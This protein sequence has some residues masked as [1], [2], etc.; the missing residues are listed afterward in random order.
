MHQQLELSPKRVSGIH[1]SVERLE[2]THR[3]EKDKSDNE[4]KKPD[5]EGSK[6]IPLS[7]DTRLPDAKTAQVGMV[8]SVTKTESEKQPM[9]ETNKIEAKKKHFSADFTAKK[10]VGITQSA[11][12]TAK[13]PLLVSD[14][15]KSPSCLKN[16]QTSLANSIKKKNPLLLEFEVTDDLELQASDEKLTIPTDQQDIFDQEGYIHVTP[17]SSQ[18]PTSKGPKSPRSPL[19]KTPLHHEE[20]TYAQPIPLSPN[21]YD[22]LMY[23]TDDIELQANKFYGVSIGPK[24]DSTVIANDS[25]MRGDS[26]LEIIYPGSTGSISEKPNGKMH[27]QLELSPKC[28][29]GIHTSVE[30]L[31]P[32]H[33]IEKDKSD[34]EAK[35]PDMEG[36]KT[37]PL[38]HDT[39]LP[40]AKATQVGMVESVTK[41]ESKKQPMKETN[42]IQAMKKH[43]SADFTPKKPAMEGSKT[44]PLSHDTCLLDVKTAQVGM[45]ESVTKTESKKQPMKKTNKIEAKKKHFFADFT[46]KKPVGITQSA[47]DTAKKPLLVSDDLKNP[48]HLKNL[49]T[50]LA[51]RIKKK[52][53]LLLEFEVTDD[54]EL[55]ASDEKLTIPTDQQDIFDQEGYI[56]V[57]PPSSQTP[58]SKGPKSPRSPLT[59]TPLHHEEPTYAQPTPLSPNHYDSLM[60]NTDDIELQANKFYGVSIG[61]K[62]DS[63][64]I[65][66]DSNMRGDSELEIIYPG[67]TGS[68][69]EKPNGKMHQQLELSPKCI[70][71]IHTSVERLEPTHGIEKDKSDNEAKKPDMEGNKTTPL[72]HDTCLPDAKTAQVGMVESVTKT[73]S[74][75]Q[76]MKKTSKIQ[77]TK[78]HLSLDF[79]PKKPDMEGSKTTPLSHDTCLPDAKTTQVGMVES[80]T[81]IESKKQ[82]MKET[83]KIQAMKKHF[84]ADFT[85][86]KPVG[87][88]QSAEDTVKK[89]L[90]VSD[91]LK[92]P[93]RLKNLQTSL[94]N[95]MK[96]TSLH[97][98]E[99]TYA[100]PTPLSPTPYDSVMCNTDDI[101]LQANIVYGVSI[102]PKD[103]STV[104]ANNSNMRGDSELEIIY[105]GSTGSISEKPNRKMHQQLELSPKR[106]SGIHT[107]VERLEPTHRIEKD[108]P[109]SEDKEPNMEGSKTT[110]LSHNTCLPDAKTTQV[111]MV[112]SVTKT[113]SKKQPMKETNKIQAMKKHLSLDFTPKKPAME[114]SK[115][116]PLSHNTCLLD[117]KTA[118]VG[119]VES[120]T[121][122]ESEKQPMKETNKIQAM[123]KHFSAD[124]TPKKPVGITQSAEDTVKKPLLVSDDLKNPSRLKNLQTSLANRIKKKNPLLLEFEVTDD[125]EL[126]ASDEKLT[127]P[128]D[129][130]DIFDQEGYIHVTPPSSQTPTSKGPKSPRSPLT[131]TP[132][133]HEEP[134][135]AQPT[136][137]SPNHYDSLMYNTDDI[138][139]QANIVYGVSIGPKD[140]STVIANDSNMRG[141]SELE[142]IYPGSTGSISEKPNGKMHQQLEL[143][144]KCISGI[145][146]SV[147]RLEPTHRIEKD[148]SDNEAKKPDMEVSKTTPLSHD[149]C[150]PDAKTA[151]V[152]MVESVTKIESK[153]QPMKKTSKIQAMKKHLSLDFTPKKPDMEGSKNTPLSHDTCLPDAKTT[154]VG[155]VESV[156]KIESKKQPMKETNKIQAM[157]KHFSADFT[158]K[159][160]VGITQSAEDTVKKPLLVSDDLKNPSRLKNLQTS[161]AN[162]MKKTSLHHEEP[163]YAQPTPLSP[164]PYD[165]VMCNTD[166][167]ELQ[168]NIVY[169]VSIGPKDDSTVIANN[170]NM[171][172]DS[173]LEIIYP[174]STGSISEKPNRKMH[175]QLELSPKCISGIHTSVERLE[176][177]HRIEKDKPDSEDK[178]P[179]MEGSKTTPLSHNTC[180]PDAK[181][182]Q[183]GMVESVTKT[184]SKKQPMKETN[185]I[186]AMKKHLSLDFT[187]KKPAMEVSKTTP[188]SHNT[189]LLDV[190]TAQVGMVE[191]VTKTESEKQPMK[192]T[193]KIQAMK[194]H[195]SADF[196]AKKPVSIT[197]SAEDTVKKPLLVSDDLKNPSRL[198]NLQTSLANRIKKKNP[199]LLEFEVT[200]DLELQASD[201]KLTIPTDQQDIFDQ[202]GYIH[203]TPPSSQ[204]PTSKGPKSPRSPLTKTPLHHEEPT[205][206]QP[207][208]LSPNHYDSLMYNTDDIELQANIVYGVSIGPKDDSTVIAND[209]NMR[210]DS[211]LEIIYPG[212]T[213]SISEKPNGKM[214]QQL[215]L[216][217]KC[218]SGIHTS[219][220]RLE[221]THRIE[222]DKSDNEAKKPDMEV[223]KTTP[224]SHDTCLPDAKTA[225]VGMVESVTKTESKKQ[226]MKKTSKIQA[227]K[228]HL[229]LDF[230]PKKPDMEGSKNTPLSHDTCLPD[231]KTTQVGMVESVTKIESKIQPMKETNKIQAMKKHFSADFTAKN[232]VGITQSA[233]DTVKKPLLVSDDLKNPSR[234]KNLQTSLANRMKKTSLHHEE[235]TY[236]QPTP[237]SPTPYDSVMCNTDDIELQANIVYGVS[238]G[239]KDD[240]TV[241]AN[242]S[243]MRGDSELEI[244][245]PGSTGSISEKPNR[246][247]HQ[248]LELS[249]KCIS[250]IHTSVERLE[251]THRIEKDKPDSEDKEPNMEGSKTT[252]LSHN[253]CLPDAKTTQV[254]MVESVTKIESKKRPMKE[255]NKIEAKKKHF[256]AEFT[257]KKPV[258]ITQSAGD[259][260]KKPL[261]VSDDLKNPSRLK[262]LQTSLANR[263]KKTSLHHEEPTYAQPTPLSPD[264]YDSLMSNTD[265]IELQTNIVYGVSIGLKDDGSTV[266]ANDSNIWKRIEDSE[267]EY[268]YVT[269]KD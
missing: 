142:I 172:G 118:Q 136:P 55:Q 219:V 206:A 8:E 204:T 43:F 194:K 64:V 166:D 76:P 145:H 175:Q 161:L 3:I 2:P 168:A 239:P 125:L 236:A 148:K 183:V 27:Q 159:N 123:K 150:L 69:S 179:N 99:P 198:K 189:C 186:E 264:S 73:E 178:E 193:N 116:T 249:P 173:E 10:P 110:P 165:S 248:Q 91:D 68:I 79:T 12:D 243:N 233:E 138:E 63:T 200:D 221:P 176:P 234:L 196:T 131:K 86:K 82:P 226:P 157:K 235:P 115:T 77:A 1:T 244:I 177:T 254:G 238:I 57:T 5:M 246:K 24:D 15:L 153:K 71:G 124:F 169:G 44:T 21:H 222:K 253:T 4:D 103:D 87:I 32:T 34:N 252:P 245:Y 230:T 156:T 203:V 210:G 247:M 260:V 182:T 171:R 40:N 128:T 94:A 195:F 100:Q 85:A 114:V 257:P 20:P 108:K 184:E 22:S 201:E 72:S 95:R 80:V 122:T 45:V 106:I 266:I 209:S 137:L 225:Q 126:Q 70:S 255:T 155:M 133:H 211:E 251:P 258:G 36:N 62:D 35:K 37:T 53:P 16:L 144:P 14:D 139:L 96:K 117:V 49:Q 29:S 112:E 188:L 104:I 6:T 25:N 212:S 83:N 113:E 151:Q 218:I 102:G 59:K 7:H 229:S 146:T 121:K 141:D 60:Y 109:D 259:T 127:I 224:L 120:V 132:L 78:K 202:E 213:G 54:L 19:T 135:Y 88:T 17:P 268:D 261:L 30:R 101:E 66:N 140:D 180:L 46:A 269:L 92:N 160:P 154:Q 47:E 214:H 215:E 51:N 26:E 134:T 90:L 241:I 267:L 147:E 39:C 119:M 170:S 74:K 158:A 265:D 263:I 223:S 93:S 52:N 84:S 89:P 48:S 262:N 42:K 130:Q 205:Y 192:E 149:T 13:K 105:P 107:S 56:H 256:S 28:I 31:E 237:L 61:P 162:R 216:S 11:E 242:N 33:G 65:A 250:G 240:S 190:K 67:S 58:T 232:P 199:L 129:Q 187:P 220:E 18:T 50:S 208:P 191:S 181:T 98:E 164:T 197:Q 97:H 217:P 23:N 231:A 174:G 38:S 185:K 228:K 41:T 111:G 9:K 81:K 207:T 143:S 163:T 167:I 227:M 75:K 152:G